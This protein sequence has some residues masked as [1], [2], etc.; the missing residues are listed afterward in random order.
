[1]KA[2]VGR[3]AGEIGRGPI[4]AESEGFVFYPKSIRKHLKVQGNDVIGVYKISLLY[5]NG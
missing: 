5:I 1:M 2:H 4:K 3:K